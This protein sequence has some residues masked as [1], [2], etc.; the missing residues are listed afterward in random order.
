MLSAAVLALAFGAAPS[1]A[2]AS[3]AQP[4]KK[5]PLAVI[6]APTT[7]VADISLA[8]LAR[9]F[10]G[11]PTRNADGQRYVPLNLPEGSA[12]R[13]RFDRQV[14]GM[15]PEQVAQHWVDQR[16]RGRAIKPKSV[17]S[18]NLATRAVAVLAGA[19]TYVPLNRAVGRVKVLRVDG[20]L[21]TDSGYVLR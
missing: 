17:P 8:D 11:L 13:M 15:D 7:K 6:M 20:K 19:I 5:Q 12:A 3:R 4:Q 14:L 2:G 1:W 16:I 21:P 10:R 9:V 18:V